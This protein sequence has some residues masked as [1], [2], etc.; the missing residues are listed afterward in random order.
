MTTVQ[1]GTRRAIVTLSDGA[2]DIDGILALQRENL[3]A[4]VG[5]EEAGRN[6]FVTVVHTR[7]ILEAMHA[8]GPSVVARCDGEVV[9]YAL[10]MPVECRSFLPVLVPMFDL[11]DGLEY[12]GAPFARTRYYVMGQICVARAFRGSGLFDAMY[13]HHRKAF[14][15]RYDV[16]VTEIARR[17]ARSLRA[18]AR[19]GFETL[20]EYRD[21]TDA[22]VVV[23][24]GMHG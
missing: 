23:G 18:H 1:G 4:T 17:N 21:A 14:A 13:A 5:E 10:T 19:V 20:A 24:M 2:A 9:G 16:I 7:P 3:A 22:W 15:D 12:R 6:G 8:S 11:L